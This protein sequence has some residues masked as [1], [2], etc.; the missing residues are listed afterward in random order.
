MRHFLWVCAELLLLLASFSLLF[1]L[2]L[3]FFCFVLSFTCCLHTITGVA[4]VA[5]A[6]E[7]ERERAR[8]RERRCCALWPLVKNMV[9]EK[10]LFFPG[11]ACGLKTHTHRPHSRTHTG[12]LAGNEAWLRFAL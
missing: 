8:D 12:T 1:A 3:F 2:S 7:R 10:L 5:L 6:N 11:Y 4:K 9:T